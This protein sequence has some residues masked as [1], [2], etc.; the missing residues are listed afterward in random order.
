MPATIADCEALQSQWNVAIGLAGGGSAWEDAGL[1]WAWQPHSGHLMLNF[2]VAIDAAA[3]ERGVE[4]AREHDA[5]VVGAWL[6]KD[7]DADPL[8][9]VGFDEGWEPWWMAARLDAMAE[10]D[11]PRVALSAD[12][13]E[14]GPGGQRLLSLTTGEPKRAWPS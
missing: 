1:R 9:A 8:K 12:V 6:S 7:V 11:D 2:P 3:A 14:Y 13:P 4:F 5:R 10:P